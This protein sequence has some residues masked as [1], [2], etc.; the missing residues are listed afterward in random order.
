MGKKRDRDSLTKGNPKRDADAMDEDG[1]EEEDF[2]MVNVDFEW[3]NFDSTIDFHGTKS[4][5]RQLLDVDSA[6]FD[7]SALADV[8]LA[9]NAVGSSV[10][11]DGRETDPYALVTAV[12]L[13]TRR[14]APPSVTAPDA[15]SFTAVLEDP[16]AAVGLVVSE[17]LINMPSE[18]A[19]PLYTMLL[20]ELDDAVEEKEPYDFTHFLLPS[21]V[22]SE[23]LPDP[24]KQKGSASSSSRAAAAS[25]SASD[26]VF[27]FHPEDEVLARFA[28]ATASY[29]FTRE[30]EANADSKRAFQDMGVKTRG[31][32]MLFDKQG[33]KA[34]V[35]AVAEFLR[36]WSVAKERPRDEGTIVFE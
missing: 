18:V 19:G 16:T 2:D 34:A 13:P 25:A 4:L 35:A 17:R 12:P 31:V 3:F 5:L 26:A 24:D 7:I 22:Y 36:V 27:Y 20:D 11:V 23:V 33:F 21:R 8:V 1:S 15:P 6:L 28:Q 9:N 30:G 10:K 29:D 32:V 14:P